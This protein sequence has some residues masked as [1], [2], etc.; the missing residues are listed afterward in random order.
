MIE[1]VRVKIKGKESEI[2]KDEYD[3]LKKRNLLKEE[4][5]KRVTKEEKAQ[6]DTKAQTITSKNVR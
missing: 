5:T 2:Y 3:L 4:K 1:K 6:P